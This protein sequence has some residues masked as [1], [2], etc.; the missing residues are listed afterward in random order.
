M[1]VKATNKYKELN[2]KDKILNKIPEAGEE[3]EVTEKRFKELT[4]TNQYNTIFVERVEVEEIETETETETEVAVAE[5]E[6]EVAEAEIE[7][8]ETEEVAED[9][10]TKNATKE[11]KGKKK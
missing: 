10:N 2:V 6:T 8:E 1:L 5:T 11:T 7:A 4:E 3:F 9:S